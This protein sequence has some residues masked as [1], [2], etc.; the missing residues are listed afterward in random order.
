[1]VAMKNGTGEAGL[2]GSFEEGGGVGLNRAHPSR[3]W[4]CASPRNGQGQK[5][6]P[7]RRFRGKKRTKILSKEKSTCFNTANFPE[8]K[9]SV[10]GRGLSHISAAHRSECSTLGETLIQDVFLAIL[11]DPGLTDLLPRLASLLAEANASCLTIKPEPRLW[12]PAL[13]SPSF[14][15]PLLSLCG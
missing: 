4:T 9:S 8:G 1:M 13:T 2:H 6:L 5:S 15:E 14:P 3:S 11:K 7:T 12:T 10:C